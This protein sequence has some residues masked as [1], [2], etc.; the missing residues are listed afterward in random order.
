MGKIVKWSRASMSKERYMSIII[1]DAK[2]INIGDQ[3]FVRSFGKDSNC[4]LLI[5]KHP[6]QSETGYDF[7]V[8]ITSSKTDKPLGSIMC[9]ASKIDMC[10]DEAWD[11]I[12]N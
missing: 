10:L 5:Q 4:N 9:E 3:L 8:S 1:D 7:T 12:Y 2:N 11:R 6:N